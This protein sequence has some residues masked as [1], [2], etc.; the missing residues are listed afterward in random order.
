MYACP[1]PFSLSPSPPP[2]QAYLSKAGKEVVK[3]GHLLPLL[4]VFQKLVASKAHD[5]EG[6]FIL[7]ALVN[8]GGLPLAD[9]DQYLTTVWN[10]LFSRWEE[11]WACRARGVILLLLQVSPTL[12]T[13]V[14]W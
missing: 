5:H 12:P 3:G 13:L 14:C 4:G 7:G 6:F 10:L 9:V 11:S 1:L 8:E 2:P